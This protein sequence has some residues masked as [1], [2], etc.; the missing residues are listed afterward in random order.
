MSIEAFDL[1]EFYRWKDEDTFYVDF[2]VLEQLK[3]TDTNQA[4]FYF[5]FACM[6]V[7]DL[8]WSPEDA[9]RYTLDW[10]ARHYFDI[11]NLDPRLSG[12]E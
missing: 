3:Q 7:D 8:G 11:E 10:A 5:D 4:V 9:G 6:L 2:Q 1:Q 12:V